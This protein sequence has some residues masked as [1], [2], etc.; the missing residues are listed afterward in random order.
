M[1]VVWILFFLVYLSDDAVS[2]FF[3][4]QL[5]RLNVQLIGL[6][7]SSQRGSPTASFHCALYYTLH[8]SYHSCFTARCI[9]QFPMRFNAVDGE[10]E[11]R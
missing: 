2:S 7:P 6:Q 1:L 10:G 4:P 11:M 3:F 9:T 8:G 5:F